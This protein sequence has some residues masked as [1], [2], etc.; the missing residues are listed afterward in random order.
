M[1]QNFLSF[2][3]QKI[4]CCM[5]IHLSISGHLDYFDILTVVNNTAMNTSIKYLFQTLLLLPLDIYLEVELLY[6]Q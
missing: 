3:G 5:Y 2:K 6:V 1:C 4:I